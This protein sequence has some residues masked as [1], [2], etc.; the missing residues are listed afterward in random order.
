MQSICTDLGGAIQMPEFVGRKLYMHK[1]RMD[2]IIL[3]GDFADYQNPIMS[4]MRLVKDHNN[5][6]YITIDEKVINGDTHRRPGIHVDFNWFENISAH[7]GGNGGSHN[8]GR[9]T[10]LDRPAKGYHKGGKHDGG[11]KGNVRPTHLDSQMSE[12]NKNGGML[13]VSNYEGCRVWRGEF[14][15]EI[16]EG[17]CCKDI[18]VSKLTSEVMPAGH[19]Y[20]LNALGIHES[21][22]IPEQGVKRSL[23]RI[24]FHPNYV[25]QK[26]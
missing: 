8:S 26:N 3:P 25:F 24:N 13:L 21:L 11:H 14:A 18:D 2:E 17:G 4:M 16:G 9:N 23:I 10:H 19:V 12:F 1:T 15:G 6:C 5:V 22:V 20:Y 7:S